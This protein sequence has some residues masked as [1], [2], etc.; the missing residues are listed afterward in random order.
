MAKNTP[1]L[2]APESAPETIE[3]HTHVAGPKALPYSAHVAAL[4]TAYED[5]NT[6]AATT[7][8]VPTGD[9]NEKGEDMSVAKHKR[10]VQDA[11]K[12]AGF[13]AKIHEVTDFK[14]GTA[15][16]EFGLRPIIKR[17]RKAKDEATEGAESVADE[18]AEAA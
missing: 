3:I 14:D 1:T 17:T 2:T 9:K 7:V 11:A 18:T 16:I 5:G 8:R 15:T 10:Y 6:E 13:S 12:A 4:R